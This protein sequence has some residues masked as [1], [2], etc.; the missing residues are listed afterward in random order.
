MNKMKCTGRLCKGETLQ[1]GVR[2]SDIHDRGFRTMLRDWAT[3]TREVCT[4]GAC[5]NERVL[6]DMDMLDDVISDYTYLNEV[7]RVDEHDLRAALS[8]AEAYD[9]AGRANRRGGS[10]TPRS[11]RAVNQGDCYGCTKFDAQNV[12]CNANL[13]PSTCGFANHGRPGA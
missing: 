7:V 4:T 3:E 8:E 2:V 13:D 5:L 11:L 1:G 12:V 10:Y 9:R 6:V